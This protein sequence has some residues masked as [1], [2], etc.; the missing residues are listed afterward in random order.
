VFTCLYHSTVV[1]YSFHTNMSSICMPVC[2]TLRKTTNIGTFL[3]VIVCT[4][5]GSGGLNVVRLCSLTCA[6]VMTFIC[7]LVCII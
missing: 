2:E 5:G 1:L 7:R 6:E 4:E 3:I